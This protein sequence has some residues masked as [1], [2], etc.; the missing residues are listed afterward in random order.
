MQEHEGQARIVAKSKPTAMNLAFTVSTSSSTEQDPI[1][2]K[3]LGILKAPCRTDWSSIGKPDARDRNHDAASSSQGWQKDAVLDVSK[4]KLV[5]TEEEEQEHLNFLED[6][7]S[8]GN[9]VASLQET[10]KSKVIWMHN[11][12]QHAAYRTWRRVLSIVRQ[13]YGISPRDD[14]KDLNVNAAIWSIFSVCHSSSCSSSWHAQNGEFEIYQESTQQ[15]FETVSCFHSH[16][17][18]PSPLPPAPSSPSSPSPSSSLL[19]L[20]LPLHP[21]APPAPSLTLPSFTKRAQPPNAPSPRH[22]ASQTPN[23]RFWTSHVVRFWGKERREERSKFWPLPPL[24]TVV[25]WHFCVFLPPFHQTVFHRRFQC[26]SV[27]GLWQEWR[28]NLEHYY[29]ANVWKKAVNREFFFASGI[30]AEFYGRT[31]KNAEIGA[32]LR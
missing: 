6:S 21:N 31:A 5:A 15:I 3:S 12:H 2:S 10:Q 18:L 11:L 4:G 16:L 25:T 29:N 1:A 30:S 20:S 27:Q 7:V 28:T 8:T 19:L 24:P 14:M 32:S 17:L 23:G 26:K 9:I 13:R 22:S